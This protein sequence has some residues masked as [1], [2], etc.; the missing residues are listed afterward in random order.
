MQVSG[1]F[2]VR[3][4]AVRDDAL[5]PRACGRRD[6]QNPGESAHLRNVRLANAGPAEIHH[7]NELA[8]VRQSLVADPDRNTVAAHLQVAFNVIERQGGLEEPYAHFAEDR[9]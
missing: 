3:L 4:I 6:L 8:Y 2:N 5:S 7:F 9:K 1:D